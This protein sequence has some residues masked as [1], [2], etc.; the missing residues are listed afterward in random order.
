MHWVQIV[1]SASRRPP[2]THALAGQSLHEL[3][4][5]KIVWSCG[6]ALC[7]PSVS[8]VLLVRSCRAGPCK[9]SL[10]QQD[11]QERCTASSMQSRLVSAPF[12]AST[13]TPVLQCFDLHWIA[14]AR[15][16][17]GFYY[18]CTVLV[19]N[20]AQIPDPFPIKGFCFPSSRLTY[21][22]LVDC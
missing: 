19:L 18:L 13:P 5:H 16:I 4:L 17:T 20:T 3:V 14:V 7:P 2:C 15:I 12:A 22:R 8:T 1:H 10:V 21:P 11:R 9:S 6:S